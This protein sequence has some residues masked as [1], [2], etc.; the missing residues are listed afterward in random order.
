MPIL[1]K[2]KQIYNDTTIVS[3]GGVKIAQ[4]SAHV[5]CMWPLSILFKMGPIGFTIMSESSARMQ[6]SLIM[7]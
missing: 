4:N 1:D 2:Y 6:M 7:W 3:G 5:I